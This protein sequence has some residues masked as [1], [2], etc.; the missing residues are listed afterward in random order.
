MS[1]DNREVQSWAIKVDGGKSEFSG[2][3]VINSTPPAT[4]TS[5][6][7]TGTIQWDSGFLY[8]CVAT[9]T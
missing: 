8:V 4:S 2:P 6:G 1:Q 5:A 9:D 7:A 3:L